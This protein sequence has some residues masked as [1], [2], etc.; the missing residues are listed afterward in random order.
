MEITWNKIYAS[1]PYFKQFDTAILVVEG[2][3]DKPYGDFLN[4]IKGGY[5]AIY[6]FPLA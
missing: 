6:L 2:P 5:L 1:P 4:N 3:K